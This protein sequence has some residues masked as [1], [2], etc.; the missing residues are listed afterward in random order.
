MAVTAG[1]IPVRIVVADPAN[2][3][4]LILGELLQAEADVPDGNQPHDPEKAARVEQIRQRQADRFDSQV[5][6]NVRANAAEVFAKR[7]EGKL[8]LK[9]AICARDFGL[10][11]IQQQKLLLAGRGDIKRLID[12][13]YDARQELLLAS[14]ADPDA[15]VQN[16]TLVSTIEPFRDVAEI[17]PFDE[18]SLFA[19]TIRRDLTDDQIT[20]LAARDAIELSRGRITAAFRLDEEWH[21]VDFTNSGFLTDDRLSKI[22]RLPGIRLL[23]LENTRISDTGLAHLRDLQWLEVLD[24]SR[25]RINGTGFVEFAALDA[26]QVL[27]LNGTHIDD[28]SLAHLTALTSLAELHLQG[29]RITDAGLAALNLPDMVHLKEIGLSRT[30]VTDQG[31]AHLRHC[32][33]LERLILVRTQITDAGLANLKGLKNLRQLLIDQTQVTDAGM[34]ELEGLSSLG[35]IDMSN[36]RVGDPGIRRLSSLRSLEFV[37]LANTLVTDAGIAELKRALPEL[38]IFK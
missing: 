18:G 24:L 13:I 17:G 19:K 15:M 11:E 8:R 9:L 14:E 27:H 3:A 25:T 1:A 36:T 38:E 30:L 2:A 4:V 34:A 7:L 28:D 32:V 29:T 23:N 31:L 26:L 33:R 35:R 5:F 6:G 37:N 16:R 20:H 12:R 21:D 10:S 22:V